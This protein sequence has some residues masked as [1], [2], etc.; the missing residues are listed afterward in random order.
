MNESSDPLPTHYDLRERLHT[1][2]TADLLGPVN[3]LVFCHA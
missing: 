3:G 1:L 2:V